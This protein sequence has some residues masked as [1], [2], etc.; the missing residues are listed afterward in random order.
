MS[1][2]ARIILL[3]AAV[4][5]AIVIGSVGY[6]FFKTYQSLPDAYA[7]WDVGEMIV[8]YMGSHEDR[9]PASWDDLRP[10]FDKF[11][12]PFD[13][14]ERRMRGGLTFDDIRD[15]IRIDWHANPLT[16]G[17]GDR[18]FHA[19]D[20]VSGSTTTWAGGEPNEMVMAYLA[21]KRRRADRHDERTSTTRPIPN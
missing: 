2:R 9:W 17:A 19:V 4:V 6:K 3:C 20:V 21:E 1:R 10:S 12:G 7:R 18:T 16:T 5:L 11:A 14:G 8:D 13:T 15:R